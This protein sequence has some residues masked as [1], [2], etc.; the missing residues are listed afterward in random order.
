MALVMVLAMVF[1]LA[2][3]APL[4]AA[5]IPH[6]TLISMP[7]ELTAAGGKVEI[8]GYGTFNSG[9]TPSLPKDQN[10]S[11][12]LKVNGQTSQWYTKK[13]D[14]TPLAVSEFCNMLI[15]NPAGGT[16][17]ISG[18]GNFKDTDTVILPSGV[19]ISWRLKVNGQTSQWYTKK[20]DCTALA[21]SQ[22]CNMEIKNVPAGGS[23]EIS[24]TGS[25]TDGKSVILPSGV[26][27]SWRLK[28][29]GQTSQWYKKNVDCTPLDAG[30]GV[31]VASAYCNMKITNVPAGGSVE[32]SGTGSFTDG[33]SVVL[34]SGVTI[35]WRL[36]V[37][38]QTSD[39]YTKNVDCTPL[40]V[41]K[42]AICQTN[43]AYCNMEIINVPAGGKVE[44]SGTGTY[45]NGE[46]VILPSG[47]TISWRLKV[48]GQTSQWYTKKVDCTPLDATPSCN[49]LINMTG[50][51]ASEAS[52]KVEISGTGTYANGEKVVLPSGVTVS[53]R[54]K[55]NGQ[56]SQ[57][58]TKK[59]DC[60]DLVVDQFC[61][62]LITNPAGGSVEISGT[63]SFKDKDTVVLPSG[64]TI[65]WRLKVNG[66][67]SQWYKKTV[68]CTDLVVDQFCNMKI[69][70]PAYAKVEISG[71]GSFTDGKSVILPSGVT[72]SYR[73]QDVNGK[74]TC[75]QTK[76]VDCTPLVPI[77]S[78]N[79]V[80]PNETW[81]EIS[82]MG[83]F[84]N[85][86][87]LNIKPILPYSY[88]LW[89]SAKSVASGWKTK[90]FS[91]ADCCGNSWD[92]TGE[93]CNMGIDLGTSD[94]WVE[95][96]GVGWFQGTTSSV[97]LPNGATIKYRLW[98]SAKSVANAFKDKAVDCTALAVG[99]EFCNMGIDLGTSDGWV[100][101]SGVGWFQGT[102]SSVYL[103]NGATIKYRLWNSAK[104]VANAFKDKTVD[105]TA[106]TVGAEFCN[107]GIDLGTSD[108]WVEIS[109]VGW[110]QGTASSV[111]LP[112]G[113]TIKYRLWNSAKSVANAFKDKTVDCTALT[114]GAEFCN[115]GISLSPN[116]LWVEISGVGWF[117]DGASV[118]LPVGA[119]AQ[120]RVWDANKQNV[121]KDWT[122]KTVD[123]AC[124][125]LVYP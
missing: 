105:C 83:W 76:M 20:V 110:F 117:Q 77:C 78:V 5:P 35:S 70:A 27:I 50:A 58:Y 24:G 6:S 51:L 29:N 71:T 13:V 75:W 90:V 100:E 33:Q 85:G 16:V 66:Q 84:K 47:V 72:I 67:T 119:T 120:Y 88:R 26:T 4:S 115:M 89:N 43:D 106:L 93:F 14:C 107:M 68:D 30:S 64:V 18:T 31:V 73:A 103:P 7:D 95:I 80:L 15:T 104:S 44:I 91:A 108:G 112:N 98:N 39:W 113:A 86:D 55:V 69:V 17:E 28:A 1:P 42:A 2:V 54:L 19:T 8:S 37:S 101:I 57:W 32:I 121:I 36:K 96:S 81:V 125:P 122:G 124:T 87:T 116:N 114:V 62:M 9:D 94:G 53:W 109:G 74:V 10:V 21:V 23:V 25:F 45:A 111:Y 48:S 61:N 52:A 60:T 92:L 118:W 123:L 99:A 63:G 102:T 49:M 82:G 12:R 3:P 22:Y 79:T 11:W 34:P 65:S 56:T 46:K 41:S 97:Y 40:D 59:V 38:G